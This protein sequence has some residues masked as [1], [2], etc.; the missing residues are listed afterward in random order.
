MGH[1]D[2]ADV[3]LWGVGLP[4]MPVMP[5]IAGY[6]QAVYIFLSLTLFAPCRKIT[7]DHRHHRQTKANHQRERPFGKGLMRTRNNRRTSASS[8]DHPHCTTRHLAIL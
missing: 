1:A 8:F 6:F 7:G 5:V 4:V 2:I 3:F